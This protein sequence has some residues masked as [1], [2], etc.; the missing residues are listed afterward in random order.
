MAGTSSPPLSLTKAGRQRS[1]YLL[2]AWQVVENRGKVSHVGEVGRWEHE[3]CGKPGLV[4]EAKEQRQKP[5][6]GRKEGGESWK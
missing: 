5:E 4:E 6:G 1:L 2:H 3:G